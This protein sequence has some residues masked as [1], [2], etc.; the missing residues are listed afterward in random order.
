MT[1]FSVAQSIVVKSLSVESIIN[2]L[3][4]VAVKPGVE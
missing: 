1:V 3:V 2:E 4:G